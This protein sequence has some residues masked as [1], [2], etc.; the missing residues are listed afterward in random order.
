M[1][2]DKRIRDAYQIQ[3]AECS[4]LESEVAKI[5]SLLDRRWHYEARLKSQESFALKVE[6]GL[7]R[8]NLVIEDFFACTIVVA[9]NAEITKA[10]ELI[11]S[12][13]EIRY[14]RPKN[15]IQTKIPPTDF[16]F[17]DLRLYCKLKP[18]NYLPPAPLHKIIFEIQ[19]KTFLQH[20]W[21]IA[22]HDLT[23]KTDA[24][25]WAKVRIAHQ[26]RAMLEHAELSIEQVEKLATSTLVAKEFME[27]DEITGIIE[28]L[29]RHWSPER[30]PRDLLRLANNTRDAMRAIGIKLE[31]LDRKLTDETRA[32]R[33]SNLEN[34]S[35]YG[36]IMQTILNSFP[37][38]VAAAQI[39]QKQIAISGAVELPPTL[40]ALDQRV[41]RII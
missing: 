21:A 16:R 28:T 8:K 41:F 31:D 20:A 39:P 35:P 10:L 18:P 40:P 27:Y 26:I 17:D 5:Q 9:N 29:K 34:L 23:Y 19:I 38:E 12:E 11:A 32:G 30:L 7:F 37:T 13:F 2:I 24:V 15:D 36:C 14:R 25:S 22:T 33:G 4:L 1:K 6:A 3:H